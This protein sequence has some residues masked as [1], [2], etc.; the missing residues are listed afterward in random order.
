MKT[1]GQQFIE[2]TAKHTFKTAGNYYF[3]VILVEYEGIEYAISMEFKG[4]NAYVRSYGAPYFNLVS[5]LNKNYVNCEARHA[6]FPN[7]DK[8]YSIPTF[9]QMRELISDI[10]ELIKGKNPKE[11][12][13]IELIKNRLIQENLENK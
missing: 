5:Q 11:K 2:N 13:T 1:K 4:S 6:L 7:N 10:K 8:R 3:K 12:E 9:K